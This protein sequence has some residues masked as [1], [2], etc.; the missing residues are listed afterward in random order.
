MAQFSC[1]VGLECTIHGA[2]LASILNQLSTIAFIGPVDTSNR[3][4]RYGPSARVYFAFQVNGE[5]ML[6]AVVLISL[7]ILFSRPI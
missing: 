1:S 5:L 4:S 2:M 6:F 7:L 3:D